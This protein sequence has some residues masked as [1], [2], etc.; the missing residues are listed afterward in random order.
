MSLDYSRWSN[1]TKKELQCRHTGA[2]CPN[3]AEFTRLMDKMQELRDWYGLPIAVTSGYRSPWHPIEQRKV[4]KG[5]KPG[6][7]TKAAVDFMVRQEDV[8]KVLAK[9]FELGFTGIGVNMKGNHRFIHVDLRK[10]PA[11]WSY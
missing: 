7:H 2:D 6:M 5:G 10:I 9:C 11:V 8:H 3:E 1:F 4:A